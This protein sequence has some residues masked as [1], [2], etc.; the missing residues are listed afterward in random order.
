MGKKITGIKPGKLVSSPSSD[1]YVLLKNP[2]RIFG[3][4]FYK[5]TLYNSA[6]LRDTTG[7]VEEPRD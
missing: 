3:R 2:A 1:T 6:E 4:Y 5:R 7:D